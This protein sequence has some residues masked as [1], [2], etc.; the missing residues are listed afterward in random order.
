MKMLFYTNDIEEAKAACEEFARAE[1][2][3]EVRRS[4]A[5]RVLPDAPPCSE[6]WIH[7][8]KD[9]HRAFM[10]CVQ[11]GIGFSRRHHAW[12]AE[13]IGIA[14]DNPTETCARAA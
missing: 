6:L 2:P 14:T 9:C 10:L 13:D 7:N 3:C 8:D 4:P 11:L 5:L 12:R 1:I